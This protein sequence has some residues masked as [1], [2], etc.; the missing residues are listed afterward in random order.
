MANAAIDGSADP[1]FFL[2]GFKMVIFV[3]RDED[4]SLWRIAVKRCSEAVTGVGQMFPRN[5]GRCMQ[6]FGCFCHCSL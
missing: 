3:T 5:A 2:A 4:F 1:S 6:C